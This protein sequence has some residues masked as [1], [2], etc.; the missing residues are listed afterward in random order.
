M[1]GQT[2]VSAQEQD[3]GDGGRPGHQR[4]GQRHQKGF[5]VHFVVHQGLVFLR[6]DHAQRND[7][8][9]DTARDPHIIGVYTHQGEEQ[10]TGE[11]EKNQSGQGKQALAKHDP[12]PSAALDRRQGGHDNREVAERIKD[13]EEGENRSPERHVRSHCRRA[14]NSQAKKRCEGL[15][16][17]QLQSGVTFLGINKVL[18]DLA[19]RPQWIIHNFVP[20]NT[21]SFHL[22]LSLLVCLPLSA[23][24]IQFIP[25]QVDFGNTL[26]EWDGFGFNYVEASRSRDRQHRIDHG[27]FSTLSEAGKDEVIEAVFARDGLGI[28]VVK[29]FL[30][31]WHQP[32]P[33]G[34]F[35]HEWSARNML[36]FV[37][38]GTGLAR[39]EG[40]DVEVITTLYGPPAWATRGKFLG[41]RDLDPAMYEPLM[42]Y[43]LHWVSFLRHRGLSVRYLSVHNEGEDFYR[44]DFKDGTQRLES[45]DY[46]AYWP[47][48]LVNTFL[49]GL[50]ER[51][52]QK[53]IQ[54]LGVTNGEPSNWTRFLNWGYAHA[55]ADDPQA[56]D[57]LGL[58]TTH[59]FVNG[60]F[61]K[62]SYG[63]INSTTVDLLRDLKPGLKTWITSYS[64]GEMD[65]SFV[66]VAHEHIYNARVN[67]LIP[68]AGMQN[69]ATYP[70]T[71]RNLGNAITVDD[72]GNYEF[73]TGYYL[74]KQL[75]QAG[76]RGTQVARTMMASPAAFLLGFAGGERGE[77]DAFVV[78]DTITIWGLP[79]EIEIKGS[80]FTRFRAFRSHENGSEKYEFVGD[81]DVVDGRIRYDPPTGTVTTFIGLA[82]SN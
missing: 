82:D 58:L 44:W 51:I 25:A 54:N 74:Y 30:D 6:E 22:A 32:E 18:Q 19:C 31:P 59:G 81:F 48:A 57:A 55:L 71:S 62:M 37:E 42:E 5:A 76:R 4:D 50:A 80:R 43:M 67:A 26:Q 70:D 33:D 75:S 40:R 9:N 36:E 16:T 41:H 66:K 47:P 8:E 12:G 46:N 53:G 7:E 23:F 20:M 27:G 77:P 34:P 78:I 14:L 52:D 29:M 3:G 63:T 69:P 60:D 79:F 39:K 10:G 35:D 13:Q 2:S 73:T 21:P 38:R 61:R 56:L 49:V 64:W 72:D 11:E 24:E 17:R 1:A 15:Q 45:F 68:W 28:E 65:T